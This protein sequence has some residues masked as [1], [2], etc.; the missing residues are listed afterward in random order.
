MKAVPKINRT[1]LNCELSFALV[2]SRVEKE[3]ADYCSRDCYRAHRRS[4]E[5][6]AKRFWAKVDKTPGQGPFGNCWIWTAGKS[7]GY[8]GFM[9]GGKTILAHRFSFELHYGPLANG[10]QACHSCD[11]R[12]CVN[13]TEMFP[14]TIAT[15][16]AD[17][18]AKGRSARGEAIA[19]SRFTASE[20]LAIRS[21]VASGISQVQVAREYN[22]RQGAI[23][24]IVRR[25]SW[26]HI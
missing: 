11:N 1:C 4:P 5:M 2:P 14:G 21:R 20:I 6:V 12:S 23:S 24:R 7:R 18:H 10:L 26:K 9:V 16:M 19:N 15:N 13:P 3:A 17:R 25:E 22:T 8:G